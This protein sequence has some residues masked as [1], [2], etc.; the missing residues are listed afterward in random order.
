MIFFFAHTAHTQVL[1]LDS[2]NVQGE[3]QEKDLLLRHISSIDS[4]GP[5]MQRAP[6]IFIP[7]VNYG[8]PDHLPNMVLDVPNLHVWRDPKTQRYGV[9]KKQGTDEQYRFSTSNALFHDQI[10]IDEDAFTNSMDI[11]GKMP[12]DKM[13]YTLRNQLERYRYVRKEAADPMFGVEKVRLS[14]KSGGENDDLVMTFMMAITWGQIYILN[15]RTRGALMHAQVGGSYMQGDSIDFS[16]RGANVDL[17]RRQRD[18]EV[19]ATHVEHTTRRS[20]TRVN[21]GRDLA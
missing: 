18:E 1:G 20:D 19:Y 17:L 11:K 21:I 6:K 15:P 14:G 4:I 5:H 7:E 13:I 3:F 16:K 12:V 9:W 2:E 8:M 10:R